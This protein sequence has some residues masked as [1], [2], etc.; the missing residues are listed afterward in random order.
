MCQ[1][2]WTLTGCV[3]SE[4]SDLVDTPDFI[5]LMERW[6]TLRLFNLFPPNL[7]ILFP[8][9]IVPMPDKA[10][11]TRLSMSSAS[12]MIFNVHSCV[13]TISVNYT[14]SVC[15]NRL[16]GGLYSV[17]SM[18]EVVTFGF[19]F[20]EQLHHLYWKLREYRVTLSMKTPPIVCYVGI[21]SEF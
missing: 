4:C 3:I 13:T 10:S 12:L 11:T 8:G 9:Y 7:L 16:Y 21:H 15:H 18:I 19:I 6:L 17:A 1:E 20:K 2:R 14:T 5:C